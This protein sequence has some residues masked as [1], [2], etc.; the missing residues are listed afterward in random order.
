MHIYVHTHIH[1]H[2]NLC[3]YIY[4]QYLGLELEEEPDI[5]IARVDCTKHKVDILK[6][7]LITKFT[8]KI[9]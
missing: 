3:M 2:I 7:Q 5:E 6:S 8:T 1:T 9:D 4:N